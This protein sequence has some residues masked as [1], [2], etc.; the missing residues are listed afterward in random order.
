M[1]GLWVTLVLVKAVG[2]VNH[3]DIDLHSAQSIWFQ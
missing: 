3:E 1:F 2:R